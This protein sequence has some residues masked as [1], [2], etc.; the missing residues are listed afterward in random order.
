MIDTIAKCSACGRLNVGNMQYIL[1]SS[2]GR[3]KEWIHCSNC[4]AFSCADPFEVIREV[5]HATSTSYGEKE[6]GLINAAFIQRL[7]RNIIKLIKKY[8]LP[9]Q[10]R[11][12]D[13]GCSF[14]GL[15]VMAKPEGFELTGVDIL[16]QA[17]DYI[18][19]LGMEAKLVSSIA[20]VDP[21]DKFHIISAID[22]NYYWPN[23]KI[24]LSEIYKRLAEG[25]LFI[26]RST[27]KS[28]LVK[29]GISIS[30]LWPSLGKNMI[31]R[32]LNDH[33]YSMPLSSLLKLAREQG[34]MVEAINIKDAFYSD[35]SPLYVRGY[36]LISSI[37][38]K[39]FKLY[40]A[41]GYIIVF[42]K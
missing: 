39:L 17:V 13:V 36:F 32:G 1:S 23:Q 41:P 16:P 15:M 4:K 42:R 37:L 8:R 28:W 35:Q 20:E 30:W 7:Y 18:R 21:G 9:K 6:T 10:N 33:R 19:S 3:E 2:R 29:S 5:T 26:L 38:Y 12:L 40:I 22:S 25:G 34:F 27:D 14:G 31:A 11:W 24:E